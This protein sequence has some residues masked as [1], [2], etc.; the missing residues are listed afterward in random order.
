MLAEAAMSRSQM[1]NRWKNRIHGTMIHI[2]SKGFSWSTVLLWIS[3][4][5][6]GWWKVWECWSQPPLCMPG[7]KVSQDSCF[8]LPPS[9]SWYK[10]GSCD[11]QGR[12]GLGH[13][14]SC[15]LPKLT[16]HAYFSEIPSCLHLWKTN[17]GRE[18]RKQK[19]R[20][21]SFWWWAAG[22]GETRGK[23]AK[24]SE[25]QRVHVRD[26][27]ITAVKHGAKRNVITQST[28]N[29]ANY[30]LLLNRNVLHVKYTQH[31]WYRSTIQ[32]ESAICPN[33]FPS[34][35]MWLPNL[36]YSV[37]MARA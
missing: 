30:T 37:F 35:V 24:L 29:I 17:A 11:E 36:I 26:R 3:S 2:W 5:E 7:T 33:Y 32:T 19:T 27:V 1:I 10:E 15:V 18:N 34:N 23:G 4:T 31:C 21:A 14:T 13:G 6:I 22:R 8:W 25:G 28:S 16:V 9:D 20:W 12:S